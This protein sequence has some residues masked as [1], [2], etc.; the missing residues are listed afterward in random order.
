MIAHEVYSEDPPYYKIGFNNNNENSSYYSSNITKEEAKMIDDFMKNKKISPLNTRL[1]KVDDVFEIKIAS[2][3]QI[4]E[5]EL[6]YL[7]E[8]TH[9]GNKIRITRGDFSF[10]M[11]EV[12]K[13]LRLARQYAANETQKRMLDHYILNF[14][15][16]DMD[17]HKNAMKEWITDINPDIETNIGYIET[18]LDP[19]GVRAEYEGFVAIV[20]KEV[21]KLF[22]TLVENAEE[23][24]TEL[25][26]NKE[27]E[28]EKF[29]KPDFTSLNIVAFACSGTPIGI[30]LPN[31][32]DIREKLGF[33][34]VDLGN[35]YPKPT[36]ENIQF[37]RE[38]T[39]KIYYKYSQESLMLLVALHE[40]LGHG[41]GKLLTKDV[42]TGKYNFDYENLL[43]PYTNEKID[44]CYLSN[45]TWSSKFGKLHSGYEECR[46]DSVA[47]YLAWFKKPLDIFF[48]GRESEYDDIVYTMFL[49][50]IKG[51]VTGLLYFNE[52]T[53]QWGQ[54]HIVA[55]Y[56]IAQ[57]L[58][59]QGDI[60]NIEITEKDGKE[61]LYINF[62]REG[63]KERWF[64]AMKPFLDKLHTLKWMGDYETAKEWFEEYAKVDDFFLHVKRI[65]EANK[66]PRR[67][68]NQPNILL[69]KIGKVEYK[70][71]DQSLEGIVQSYV[72]RF[73]NI[74]YSDV[75]DEW[76]NNVEIFRIKQ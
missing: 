53:K 35:V 19:L 22:S 9:E 3:R 45:E 1:T 66:L 28:K 20:N 43:N 72:E 54:A 23:L 60:F 6:S 52:A 7:G 48:E 46:A 41:T 49:D 56:V 64:N 55:G 14:T 32:D 21:S 17:E 5:H 25:P 10:A 44:T 57:V 13:N 73:P 15:S 63:F 61:Y 59:Q 29:H 18:Y 2:T 62:E 8:F 42:E 33:K 34:N 50:I 65:V 67:L 4:L 36:Y 27:F 38:E 75:Y 24:I 31:Y 69:N 30:N 76:L 51:S 74:F 40:L 39:K 58:Y 26:W 70:D 11:N 47:L 37:M 16:G 12:V 71:Y 68:E